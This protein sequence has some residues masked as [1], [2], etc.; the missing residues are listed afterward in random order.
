MR[1]AL[2]SID[3]DPAFKASST[4]TPAVILEPPPDL[5][6]L[7]ALPTNAWRPLPVHCHAAHS[8][9]RNFEDANSR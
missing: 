1:M 3:T 6:A 7:A 4:N 5:P 2:S 9:K 8:L